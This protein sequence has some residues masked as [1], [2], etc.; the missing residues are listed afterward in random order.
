MQIRLWQ[1]LCVLCPFV[2]AEDIGDALRTVWQML[3][4][5][6]MPRTC[7]HEEALSPSRLRLRAIAWHNVVLHLEATVIV[8]IDTRFLRGAIRSR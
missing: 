5:Q 6:P 4:V 7:L 3:L 8:S 2:P 1:A